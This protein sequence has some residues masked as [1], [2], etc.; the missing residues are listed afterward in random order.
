MSRHNKIWILWL[1]VVAVLVAAIAIVFIIRYRNEKAGKTE[2]QQ[3]LTILLD[4][5]DMTE[6]IISPEA[7]DGLRVIV[8][9][10]EVEVADLPFGEEHKLRIIQS[11]GENTVRITKESVYMY[12][13][14]C[15]GLD[16]VFMTEITRDNLETRAYGPNIICLPHQVYVQVQDQ[17]P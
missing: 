8:Y 17:R 1:S 9:I 7:G 16:C 12:D 11:C 6:K 10:G 2:A 5:K 15:R 4:G 3:D 14:D 13:A